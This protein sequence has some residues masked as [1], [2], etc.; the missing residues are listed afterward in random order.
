MKDHLSYHLSCERLHM[1]RLDDCSILQAGHLVGNRL[2]G[3]HDS[4]SVQNLKLHSFTRRSSQVMCRVTKEHLACR[5]LRKSRVSR[6][7]RYPKTLEDQGPRMSGQASLGTK[8]CDHGTK[9]WSHMWKTLARQTEQ[10]F[11]PSDQRPWM[12]LWARHMIPT[13]LSTRSGTTWWKFG[14]PEQTDVYDS[15][16]WWL[17]MSESKRPCRH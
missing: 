17:Q 1:V 11:N 4:I 15:Y 10:G 12:T 7:T 5:D 2:G 3:T 14:L 8:P 9:N 16:A 13:T 6:G